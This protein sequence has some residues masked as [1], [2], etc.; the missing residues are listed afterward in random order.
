MPAGAL[1]AWVSSLPL[2]QWYEIPGTALSSVD[3]SPRP[4]GNTGPR[5]KIDAWCGASLKRV[6]SL[7]ILGAAGG[8]ADYAGNEVNALQ[9]NAPSP[10]WMQ[11]RAPSDNSQIVM[12][13][14]YYLDGRPGATHTYYA[15]Q[16]INSLN[17][18]MV[19]CRDGISGGNFPSAP[20]GFP[21]VGESWSKSFNLAT[22]DWDAPGY[23]AQFPGSG[24]TTAA[25]CAKH[26]WTEDV[27]YSRNWGTGWY[28]WTRE[29]NAWHRLSGAGR[30]PWYAGAAIDPTRNRMLVVGGYSPVDPLLL[31]L[32]GSNLGGAFSGLGAS[33]LRLTNYSGLIYDEASDRFIA[34]ANGGSGR[35]EITT[36]EAGS[37]SVARPMVSGTAPLN[38]TNGIHNSA[39][40][41]P[42]LRGFVI[43][44][45]YDGNVFFMRTSG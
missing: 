45:K 15:S 12:D 10:R 39:Q 19:F 27:Y 37:L 21:Y 32:D 3:P 1:P 14:A 34:V 44:N 38:R 22:Q 40:Y 31:G 13:T 35:I 30:N 42:E 11:L 18:F 25:L 26:P 16:F 4:L 33:A 8:H 24:D 17:R 9:L 36:I 2:W 20:A 43:A 23:V 28:R 29:S 6:G 41:V 7:Y 5:A